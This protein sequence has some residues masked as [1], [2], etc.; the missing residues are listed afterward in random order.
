MFFVFLLAGLLIGS[1]LNVCI[2]RIPRHLSVVSPARS[3]CPEC[4][5]ELTWW[6]NIPVISWL[7]LNGKCRGCKNKISGR[8]PFIEILSCIAGGASF[9]HFGA[10]PTGVLIYALLAALI[11]ITFIDLEF[12]IIPNV[13]SYPGMIIGLCVGIVSQFYPVFAWPITTG[14][15]DSLL[16]FLIGGGFFYAIAVMYYFW[17]GNV[18]LGGGDIKLM[19]MTG[20]LLGWE[21]V[22]PTI[23][24]G[25]VS[26]AVVGI[27]VMLIQGTGRKTEIPFG[28][29]LSLGAVLYVFVNLP[30][31][32]FD[33]LY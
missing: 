24:A 26:G 23:F 8:Y 4:K 22:G 33:L 32:R 25:A 5:R 15:T 17:T 3:Y 1:F 30:F 18:G 29:W 7:I 27:L 10:T 2:Y 31:F 11:V 14:A 16:G 28:P 13:I 20:A 9:L 19:G 12:K 6:E 21:S